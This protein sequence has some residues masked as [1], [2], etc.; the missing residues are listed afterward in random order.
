MQDAYKDLGQRVVAAAWMAVAEHLKQQD[1]ESSRVCVQE[2][3][4][5]TDGGANPSSPRSTH[6]AGIRL[7]A[8]DRSRRGVRSVLMRLKHAAGRRLEARANHHSGWAS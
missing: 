1:A 8:I 3:W 5:S 7:A 6:R 2:Q 4:R